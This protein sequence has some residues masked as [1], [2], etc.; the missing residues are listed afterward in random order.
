MYLFNEKMAFLKLG[1]TRPEISDLLKDDIQKNI[2]P[3]SLAVKYGKNPEKLLDP[4]SIP[5]YADLSN[6]EWEDSGQRE[7]SRVSPTDK[8]NLWVRLPKGLTRKYNKSN[9]IFGD[10]QEFPRPGEK[11]KVRK[12]TKDKSLEEDQEYNVTGVFVPKGHVATALVQVDRD[13]PER[14]DTTLEDQEKVEKLIERRMESMKRKYQ[15]KDGEQTLSEKTME[16]LTGHPR[17]S[18]IDVKYHKPRKMSVAAHRASLAPS[19][20]LS[21]KRKKL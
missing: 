14:E 9:V 4:F 8:R 15:I 7:Y 16:I 20:K 2:P 10:R 1:L 11:I 13:I 12:R 5:G 17:S 3:T 19:A 18:K 6:A 21:S